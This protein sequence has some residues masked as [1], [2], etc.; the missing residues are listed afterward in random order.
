MKAKSIKGKT[1]EEIK[2]A[3]NESMADG[4]KPTLAVVFLSMSQDRNSVVKLLDEKGISILVQVQMVNLLMV[5][6]K[7]IQQP[8]FC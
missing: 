8:S 2:S 1:P 6:S 7:K 4:F 5:K 3:L